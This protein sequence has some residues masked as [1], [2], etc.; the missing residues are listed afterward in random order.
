MTLSMGPVPGP[1]SATRRESLVRHAPLHLRHGPPPLPDL[2]RTPQDRLIQLE[3]HGLSYRYPD[4]EHGIQD[5]NLAIERGSFTVVT[6]RI[7][8]GKT[9]LIRV[10]LGLLP[11]D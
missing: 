3:A 4:S 1:I 7:G 2:V 9:T 5:V 10:L 8:S 11:R 6:G